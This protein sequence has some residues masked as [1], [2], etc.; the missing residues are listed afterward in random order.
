M[1]RLGLGNQVL[2]A[3]SVAAGDQIDAQGRRTG[4]VVGRRELVDDR[5]DVGR[6]V[7]RGLGRL[8]DL[9][10]DK[11]FYCDGHVISPR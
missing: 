11:D 6:G 2:I 10:G 4:A 7:L 1:Q 9:G 5:G 8:C 3:R